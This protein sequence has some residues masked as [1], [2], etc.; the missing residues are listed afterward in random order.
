[1][2]NTLRALRRHHLARM[3]GQWRRR[4][5]GMLPPVQA[6]RIGRHAR[7][8]TLCSCWLCGNP[9]R[10]FGESTLQERRASQ[11][12]RGVLAVGGGDPA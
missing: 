6:R 1:M 8:A 7:T 11:R 4:L 10:H 5:G 2:D 9:R 12:E 3:K